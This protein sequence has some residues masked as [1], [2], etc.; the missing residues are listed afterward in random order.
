MDIIV[1]YS[2]KK[3]TNDEFTEH[4][5]AV[6]SCGNAEKASRVLPGKD[7]CELIHDS[8]LFYFALT[9]HLYDRLRLI[10]PIHPTSHHI[11]KDIHVD[12]CQ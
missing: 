2:A 7:Y 6:N 10:Y 12:L 11:P 3:R 4:A 5:P 9:L 1:K 8:F